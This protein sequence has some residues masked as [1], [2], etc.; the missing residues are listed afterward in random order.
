MR[1]YKLYKLLEEMADKYETAD[2]LKDDPSQFMHR[3]TAVE[4]I[5]VVGLIAASLSL[6]NR[7]Q[8]LLKIESI[9]SLMHGQ[10]TTWIVQKE[11]EK[12][13]SESSAKFYRF[14]S[15]AQLRSFFGAIRSIILQYHSIGNCLESLYNKGVN[16]VEGLIGCF[17][18][19]N[20]GQLIPKDSSSAC[21]RINMYLR[22]MVRDN[23]PVDMGVWKWYDK[24]NLIILLDT[25]VMQESFRLG[26]VKKKGDTMSKAKEITDVMKK[27][28]KND[29][30]RCDYALFGIGIDKNNDVKTYQ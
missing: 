1:R 28:W 7:K 13:F 18:G 27:I 19:K 20:V 24:S 21:K 16:P 22:W 10:P 4:D 14:F 29:P 30:C 6:G 17:K 8:I 23:S 12:Y 26:I 25:H 11:Y 2:F 5:E 9:C 3:Y 15:Y